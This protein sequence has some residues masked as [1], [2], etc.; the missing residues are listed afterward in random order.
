MHSSPNIRRASSPR[1]KATLMFE[2]RIAA[3][4][5]TFRDAL[6][7]AARRLAASGVDTPGSDARR[8]LAAA[9]GLTA[10]DLI[11]RDGWPIEAMVA[12]D[13]KEMVRRRGEGEPVSRVLGER[14]FYG[15]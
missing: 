14:E 2:P 7:A 13:L 15:R 4:V 12:A 1:W 10:A 3:E 6:R 11:S 5:E 8:L 9:S